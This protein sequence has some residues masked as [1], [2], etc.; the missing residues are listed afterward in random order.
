MSWCAKAGTLGV[1]PFGTK[2]IRSI[3]RRPC[4]EFA[5]EAADLILLDDNFASIVAAIEQGRIIYSN[6]RKFVYFLLAQDLSG[7]LRQH[8]SG[9]GIQH[10]TGEVLGRFRVP[11]PP[12]RDLRRL[13]SGFD[14][15]FSETQRLESLYRQKLAAL[16][17]LKKSLLDRAFN[18]LL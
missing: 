1:P 2:T 8:F 16:D 9:T 11:I 4:T 3:S 5:K 14:G 17:A 12:L 13:V 18:G 10:F 15:L 6:I 7:E